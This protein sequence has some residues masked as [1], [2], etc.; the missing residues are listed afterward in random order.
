[1]IS[2]V[3]CVIFWSYFAWFLFFHECSSN[4]MQSHFFR[5]GPFIIHKVSN[6]FHVQQMVNRDYPIACCSDIHWGFDLSISIN[7]STNHKSSAFI[8]ISH[9]TIDLA[10]HVGC[11]ITTLHWYNDWQAGP[12]VVGYIWKASP[13]PTTRSVSTILFSWLSSLPIWFI[14]LRE[15]SI[16]NH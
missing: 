1:M 15:H 16:F 14:L 2:H 4:S 11:D 9:L 12:E 8:V 3:R 5:V 6:W 13:L 7:Q 10:F